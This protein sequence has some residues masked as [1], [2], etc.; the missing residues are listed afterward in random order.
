[1]AS[2]SFIRCT[3]PSS[4]VGP[5]SERELA[6]AGEVWAATLGVISAAQRNEKMTTYI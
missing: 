2:A 3:D 6:D 5:L 1:V 4:N